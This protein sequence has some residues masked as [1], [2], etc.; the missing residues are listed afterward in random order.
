MIECERKRWVGLAFWLRPHFTFKCKCISRSA[1]V[2]Y[3]TQAPTEWTERQSAIIKPK[4]PFDWI[5]FGVFGKILL[6]M[7]AFRFIRGGGGGITLHTRMCVRV[8]EWQC[9]TRGCFR[10]IRGLDSRW[11]WWWLAGMRKFVVIIQKNFSV[12]SRNS[13]IEL[14]AVDYFGRA[15]GVHYGCISSYRETPWTS[16]S[17]IK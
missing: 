16:R 9:R 4:R 8:C 17:L 11:W 2:S 5:W 1:C 14:S 15:L 13:A 3:W 6:F 12:E 10:S 7:T